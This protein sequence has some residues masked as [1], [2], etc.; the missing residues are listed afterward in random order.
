VCFLVYPLPIGGGVT[1][2]GEGGVSSE[3][4]DGEGGVTS[5]DKGV[6]LERMTVIMRPQRWYEDVIIVGTVVALN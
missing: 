6:S 3:G 1:S 2:E 4:E 5:E